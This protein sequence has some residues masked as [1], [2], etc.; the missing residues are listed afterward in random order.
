MRRIR[1]PNTK[2]T[3]GH[4]G[5]KWS[6]EIVIDEHEAEETGAG[7][8]TRAEARLHSGDVTALVGVGLARRN[9]GDTEVPEIG[10]EL[11]VARALADL[12]H[13]LIEATVADLEAATS[14]RIRLTS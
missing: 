11:A 10:D 2:E 3:N 14:E 4:E 13:Q 6:V 1:A 5:K 9:P 12:A 8:R 7:S